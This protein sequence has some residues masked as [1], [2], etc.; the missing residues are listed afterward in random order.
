MNI[1]II[2]LAAVFCGS[3]CSVFG[4]TEFDSLKRNSQ[5]DTLYQLSSKPTFVSEYA[6]LK[7]S[8]FVQP[9]LYFDNN[10]VLNND[11]FV[12]SQIPTTQITDIKFQRFHISANQSRLGFGFK[13]PKAKRN[14]SALLEADFLSSTKGEN[15]YFRLRHAYIAFGEFTIGQ[16]YT[17]F[18]D[19]N[20]GP[21][22][23]D[24]EGPNSMP[25]SRVAQIR[26][27]RQIK[28]NLSIIFAIEEP[29]NDY[30]PLDST[31]PLKASMPELVVKPRLVF[32]SGHWSNSVIYKP[33][34]YTDQYYTFKKKRATWG[35]T[36]S[37]VIN[38]PERNKWN[39]FG[40]KKRTAS[41]FA[42]IGEGTQGSVND[43]VGLGYEAFP[44]SPALL[45]TLLYY[46]GY[47]AYSF[48]VNK[49]WSSTYVYSYLYQQKP[50]HITQIFKHSHYMA[51]NAIYAINKHFTLGTEILYGSKENHD[52]TKGNAIRLLCIMRLLF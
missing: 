10:N 30:T 32:K 3:I 9:A 48:V 18:G 11:L 31:S 47:V 16:T 40:I 33:L 5:L 35:Y 41:I 45:E 19:V 2:F 43:F 26:W 42:I 7:I 49:R 36:S 39:P 46:G 14:I 15:T 34:I 27:R 22:T 4:Q 13:F 38:L 6:E 1:K 37:L 52:D 51:G 17:N 28:D 44:K 20:A 24:L 25:S 50:E 21:N 8:G 29:K 23:L 12:T